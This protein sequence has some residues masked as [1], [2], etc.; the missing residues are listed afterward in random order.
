LFLAVGS[1]VS[2]AA[3][4]PAKEVSLRGPEV[5]KLDWNTRSLQACDLNR[6]G[7]ND[8]VVAN[9]DRSTIEILYQLKPGA[10]NETVPKSLNP[11][12]WEPVVEDAR[13]RKITVTAGVTIFDLAVADLNGDGRPD[14]IYTGEP[15]ALTIRY[16]QADGE[17]LEKKITEA[18][19]PIQFVGSMKVADLNGDGRNDLAIL[20][21]KELCVYYQDKNGELAAPERY[22]LPDEG[23]YGLEICDVDGDGKPDLVYLC[24]NNR[25]A[26]RVRLQTSERQFGPE[27]AYTIKPTRCTLQVLAQAGG[28]HPATFADAQ[29]QTGQL[30]IFT[31]NRNTAPQPTPSL[32][33]RV[34]S[35]RPGSKAPFSYAMADLNGD[36][37][38]D[39]AVSDP[40]GA[41]VFIYLRQKDGGFS[42]AQKYPVFADARSIAAGPWGEGGH[43]ALFVAS[44][45]EQAIGVSVFNKEG[46]LSYPQPLPITGRP[47]A[48]AAGDLAGDGQTRLVVLREEKGKRF[49]DIMARKGTSAEVVK[50]IELAGLKTDPKAVRLLDANQDG[51]LD[52]AVFTPLDNMRLFVQG[53]KFE[54][55][56]ASA[57]SSF[58]RGLVD[59]LE[60]SALSLGEINGDGKTEMIVSSAG[61]ARALVLNAAGEL[62]VIDQYNARDPNSEIAASLVLPDGN[63]KPQIVLYDKKTEQFQILVANEHGLYRVTDTAVAGKIEVVATDVR[64]TKNGHEAFVFGRDRFWWLP[65]SK[66]DFTA[67][68][69]T[70]HATDLPK[71]SYSDVI[72]GDLNA[73]GKSEIVCVDPDKNLIEILGQGADDR[74]DGLLHFKVFETDQ[75]FQGRKGGA[76]EPR[77]TIVADVTGDGKKD[78]ILLVHDRILVYPQE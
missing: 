63:R 65:L 16:Q 64:K 27:L 2:L 54:F 41:Q 6:D 61:F 36:G 15:Q 67:T 50:S 71:V 7:L 24:A 21:L 3:E 73:D 52:I 72:A 68:T 38:E 23:C 8:L 66:D 10:P 48:L 28:K 5:V 55:T 46:R 58:R 9:N 14:L 1:A 12:R 45:K 60:S 19:A 32:R 57:G 39:I 37:L 47:L 74:W 44:A 25:D 42:N 13:F 20:G 43:T 69:L 4:K 49:L 26:L 33:P 40:D 75:H 34:F 22:T 56:D 29:D 18:P 62:T 35:P 70:T 77:E 31:L 53:E 59:S 51:K 30:E 76:L 11:N 78:L 17:W